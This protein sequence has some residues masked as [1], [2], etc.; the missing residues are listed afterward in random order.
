MVNVRFFVLILSGFVAQLRLPANKCVSLQQQM[1]SYADGTEDKKRHEG[2]RD[3]FRM[4]KAPQYVNDNL[5]RKEMKNGAVFKCDVRE[6]DSLVFMCEAWERFALTLMMKC[7]GHADRSRRRA[8][9]EKK[10]VLWN[11]FIS[12][13]RCWLP[14]LALLFSFFA[15]HSELY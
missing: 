3:F 2:K 7:A 5:L 15:Q 11:C 4:R 14:W 12:L 9:K 8:R 13:S 6:A 10:K 1:I